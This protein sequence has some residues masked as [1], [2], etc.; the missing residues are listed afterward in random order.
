MLDKSFFALC[1]AF[2]RAGCWSRADQAAKPLCF[3]PEAVFFQRSGQ[4]CPAAFVQF[5][6]ESQSCA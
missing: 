2:G 6:H 1:G 3:A 5:G 4:T